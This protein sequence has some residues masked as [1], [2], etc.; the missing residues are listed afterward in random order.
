VSFGFLL[1]LGQVGCKESNP[2]FH[3]A[4]D[5]GTIPSP[6]TAVVSPPDAELPP[7]DTAVNPTDADQRPDGNIGPKDGKADRKP[8]KDEE[9]GPEP[10][11]KTV[12]ART[13]AGQVDTNIARDAGLDTALPD[14]NIGPTHDVKPISPDTE[15]ADLPPQDPDAA[16]PFDGP[17][18]DTMVDVLPD[19][20]S[21]VIVPDAEIS[22]PDTL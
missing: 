21:P 7:T 6:D 10:D 3:K 17:E 8:D 1:G 16:V 13:E 5:S 19:T 4:V 18:A 2:A 22:Q 11:A 9:T 14:G 12:D 20:E 15:Q